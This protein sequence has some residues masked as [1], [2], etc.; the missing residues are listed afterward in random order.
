MKGS[1]TSARCANTNWW[2]PGDRSAPARATPP[3]S[4]SSRFSNRRVRWLERTAP[5]AAR[6]PVGRAPRTRGHPRAAHLGIGIPNLRQLHTQIGCPCAQSTCGQRTRESSLRAGAAAG[7]SLLLFWALRDTISQTF[8][9]Q[10]LGFRSPDPTGT[11]IAVALVV[12][13]AILLPANIRR[14]SDFILWLFFVL[15]VA[16]ATLLAQWIPILGVTESTWLG[17]HCSAAVVLARLIILA[18]PRNI[19]PKLHLSIGPHLWLLLFAYSFLVYALLGLF[20][21][22]HLRYL[23]IT[24]VYV[25]REGLSQTYTSLPLLGYLLPVQ[26]NIINPLLMARGIMRIAQDFSCLGRP[27]NC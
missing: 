20:N 3:M 22:L 23:S 24:D 9:Y 14:P 8:A 25:A 11:S 13:V 4:P 17:V 18:G 1:C 26:E 7:Y 21:G 5:P 6:R 19:S 2:S 12:I 10:G 27:G 16:P 15:C